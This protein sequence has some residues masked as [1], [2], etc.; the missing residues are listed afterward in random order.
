MGLRRS[1]IA[2]RVRN[3]GPPWP[4]QLLV[5]SGFSEKK[6]KKKKTKNIIKEQYRV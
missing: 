4:E 6:R 1:S 3:V 5:R 2:G